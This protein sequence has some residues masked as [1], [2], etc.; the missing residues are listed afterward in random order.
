MRFYVIYV[1]SLII[2]SL[3]E[4]AAAIVCPLAEEVIWDINKPAVGAP[5]AWV[6][7]APLLLE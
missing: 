2:N 5:T 7:L 3:V 4:T 1:E 6:Q